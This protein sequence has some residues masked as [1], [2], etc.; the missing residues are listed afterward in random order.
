[1]LRIYLPHILLTASVA[2]AGIG[3]AARAA[4]ADEP[5]ISGP[6]VHDNLAVFFLHGPSRPGPVPL[7]LDEGLERGL[8]KVLETG[9]VAELK[10]E[11]TGTEDVLIHAGD[12]VKGGQQDRVVTT[13][14]ILKPNSC[15]VPLNVFCVEAGRWAARGR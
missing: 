15:P 1:M 14:F 8:V 2:M 13:T 7:T 11:N 5:S 10:V 4:R 9:T 12:I 3:I 6:F